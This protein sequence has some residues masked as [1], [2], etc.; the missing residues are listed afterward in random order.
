M[1]LIETFLPRY[2]FV[3]RH[4]AMI[5]AEPAQVFAALHE[6]DLGEDAFVRL[7]LAIRQAPALLA[8]RLGGGAGTNIARSFGLPTFTAL[9]EEKDRELAFGLAGRFWEPSGGIVPIATA[10]EFT[11]FARPG[12]AKLVWNFHL[13]PEKRGTLLSTETRVFCPDAKSRALFTF[14]WI[15][16]RAGSGLI[17]RRILANV[18]S[19]A[20]RPLTPSRA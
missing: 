14:Y 20:E 4:A 19:R 3:E 9:G 13:E 7:L 8:H 6:I 5:A 17:R 15:V 18:R 12:T 10:A 16:I 11:R 2:H 1:S